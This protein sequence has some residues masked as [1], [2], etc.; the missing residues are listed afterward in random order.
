[1][2]EKVAIFD[3]L[4]HDFKEAKKAKVEIDDAIAHWLDLYDG[5][6]RDKNG[7]IISGNKIK[8]SRI[9][10]REIA[11]HIELQKPNLVLPFVV[12][13]TPIKIDDKKSSGS[14]HMLSKWANNVFTTELSRMTIMDQIADV[15][16]KEGTAWLHTPWKLE[17]KEEQR[18]QIFNS[19][20]EMALCGR[21]FEEVIDNGDGTVAGV[22]TEVTTVEDRPDIQV[23]ENENCYPDPNAKHL[24]EMDFF[25]HRVRMTT[26]EL[27]AIPGLKEDKIR[28]LE[29]QMIDNDNTGSTLTHARRELVREKGRSDQTYNTLDKARRKIDIIEYWGYYDL[30]DDG[31]IV[32]ILAYW[33]EK[34]SV[35][36]GA[37]EMPSSN[38]RIPFFN[39]VYSRTSFALWGAPPAELIEQNQKAKTG[40]MR[41]FFDN[42][43][44]SNNGQKFFGKGSIDALNMKKLRRGDPYIMVND[45]NQ[46]VDG[47][48]NQIP[49][50]AFNILGILD[51]ENV[52]LMGVNPG[53]GALGQ[54]MTSGDADNV[55]LSMSQQRMR[56][57]V[58]V[59]SEALGLCIEQWI[60]MAKDFA[61]DEELESMQQQEQDVAYDL[62]ELTRRPTISVKVGTDATR[63]MKLNQ[64]NKLMQQAKTLAEQV[65]EG[66]IAK[67]VADMFDE[68]DRPHDAEELRNYKPEPSPQQ[69]AMMELEMRQK[70][71]EVM[72]LE[73]EA[74][75]MMKEAE[76]SHLKAQARMIEA[77]LALEKQKA[78]IDSVAAKTE[79]QRIDNA[80]KPAQ[81]EQEMGRKELE[82]MENTS[83]MDA[84]QGNIY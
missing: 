82:N 76:T 2:S 33:G 66:F 13:D 72:K 81:A 1:M 12:A 47:S 25:A 57:N 9:V 58:F 69:T 17:E 26:S 6:D 50:S 84:S 22:Y 37:V 20:E 15:W 40:I 49:G 8:K 68:F 38:G 18:K 4:L 23:M 7:E 75:S 24:S 29:Q 64:L 55:T 34:D 35:F 60:A 53:N 54:N 70:T 59:M 80:I 36:L 28:K 19:Y 77:N 45:V 3:A 32:P 52:D 79:G 51:K 43:S 46:M 16:F 63:N 65:P 21:E 44:L 67:L 42:M 56:Y 73:A 83:V 62:F 14:S 48:F 30:N 27:E 39:L 5:I 31:V 41:G 78:D 71:A 61:T 74:A 10:M 11:K